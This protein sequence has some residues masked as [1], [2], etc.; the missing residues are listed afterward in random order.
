MMMYVTQTGLI[1]FGFVYI[2]MTLYI[3]P[4][5][6]HFDLKFPDYFKHA[7]LIGL[8]SPLTTIGMI[9]GLTI[10]CLLFSYVP[11][12]VHV[13]GVRLVAAILVGCELFRFA[14]LDTK[15]DK[16]R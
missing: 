1:F 6:S 15:R 3:F 12:V 7:V 9:I 2:I 4:V 13:I 14:R 16:L 5:W 8:Y 11:G 10:T